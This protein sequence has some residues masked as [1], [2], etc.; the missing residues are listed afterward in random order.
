MPV[1]HRITHVTTVHEDGV[2]ILGV[3]ERH[4]GLGWHLIFQLADE[5]DAQD[6]KL[7]MA[8]YCI[9]NVDGR[10]HYGGVDRCELSENELRL[11]L[12]H[13]AAGQ[14]GLPTALRIPLALARTEW[15]TLDGGLRRLGVP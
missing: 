10:T 1:H 13:E 11:E 7:G 8:T 9:S 3:A 2:F 12:S 4:H 5:F 15:E 6:E 14:L